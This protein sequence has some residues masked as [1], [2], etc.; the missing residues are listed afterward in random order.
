MAATTELLKVSASVKL[1]NGTDAQGN[2]RTVSVS[3]GSLN[4]A[5][6]DADSVLEIAGALQ[7]CLN[8]TIT[9]IEKTEISSISAA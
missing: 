5:S 8:K 6:F 2:P 1:D 3:L 4:K 7:P 9:S